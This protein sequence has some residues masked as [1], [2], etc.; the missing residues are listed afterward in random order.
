MRNNSNLNIFQCRMWD[1]RKITFLEDRNWLWS[2]FSRWKKHVLNL[3]LAIYRER[4][5]TVM[6]NADQ[7]HILYT[8]QK[9][10]NL[11]LSISVIRAWKISS[12]NQSLITKNTQRNNCPQRTLLIKLRCRPGK[13]RT[14]RTKALKILREIENSPKNKQ[15]QVVLVP[16]M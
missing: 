6:Q 9:Y 3:E 2:R 11:L 1:N 8:I 14:L 7:G 13:P 15:R 10:Y 5:L 12:Q 4:E 16:K